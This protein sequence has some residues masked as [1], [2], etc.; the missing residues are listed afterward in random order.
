[1]LRLRAGTAT[2]LIGPR[3][4][5]GMH[6]N[7]YCLDSETDIRQ[8]LTLALQDP[9]SREAMRRFWAH[10]QSDAR[11]AGVKDQSIVD[12]IARLGVGGPLIVFVAVDTSVHRRDTSASRSKQVA[13]AQQN[14][15]QFKP[16]SGPI[17]PPGLVAVTTIMPP[18]ATGT[19]S[20]DRSIITPPKKA[21]GDWTIAEKL[22]AIVVRTADSDKLSHDTQQQ[23]KGMLSDPKFVAWLVGSL[24]IWFVSHFFV[25]GEILDMLLVGAALVLSGVGIFMALESLIG[26]AHLIGE[27]VEATRRAKDEKD[28]DAAADILANI[29]VLIG[30]TV[31]IAAL[32]HATTRATSTGKKVSS[33]K[34]SP[35]ERVAKVEKLQERPSEGPLKAN[36]LSMHVLKYPKGRRPNPTTYIPKEV[37]KATLSKF[38]KG[39]TKIMTKKNFKKY[40]PAQKDGT[41]FV[42]PKEEADAL[43]ASGDK[44]AIEKA[45]GLPKNFLDHDELVRVD[46]PEPK[47]LGLRIPSGNEAGANDLWQP[48]G[49]LPNG[50][51]EAVIDVGNAPPGSFVASPID[52]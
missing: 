5:A 33:V 45:L 11:L 44:R 35:P 24:L 17:K 6:G 49:T 51:T 3:S 13:E 26:A 21:V 19:A 31:L 32:T 40:G 22:S 30:I 46:F 28:L 39:A 34:K 38:D 37:I 7:R 29:I 43:L 1:M 27:F 15:K 8:R 14:Q 9:A 36:I 2:L 16:W 23:L 42:L 12:R 10:W 52:L 18:K 20:V 50:N 4:A 25:V 41:S 47:E 48:G